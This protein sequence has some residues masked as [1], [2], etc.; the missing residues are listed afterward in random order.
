MNETAA[1]TAG[2]A[3]SRPPAELIW[4]IRL[5][6]EPST[7]PKGQKSVK[8]RC[9]CSPRSGIM[10]DAERCSITHLAH[11]WLGQDRLS[12]KAAE[13]TMESTQVLMRCSTLL[14]LTVCGLLVAGRPRRITEDFLTM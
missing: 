12:V 13:H 4:D 11:R 9:N 8:H 7:G 3:C 2:D 1:E 10:A 6:T 5:T 14:L